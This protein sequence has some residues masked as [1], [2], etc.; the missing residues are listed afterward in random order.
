MDPRQRP[1]AYQ[2]LLDGLKAAAEDTRLRLLA[3]LGEAELTVS[4]L[5][6][7]LGQSQPRISRHLKLLV[8]AGLIERFR[9]ASWTFHRRAAEGPGAALAKALAA[10]IDARDPVLGRD[11]ERL[12]QVRAARAAAAQAYFRK[13]ARQWDEIRGLHVAEGAVEAAVREALGGLRIDTLL[14]LGTGTGRMLELFGPE[15][16]RGVGID[17]NPEMLAMARANLE[18]AGLKHCTVRQGDIY[19]L[20]LGRETFDVVILHQVLHFLDDG[21][22]AIQEAARM[23][24]PGGRLLVVDFAPHALEFLRDLHAHRRLGFAEDS[25]AQWMHAAGLEVMLHRALAP[26][27]GGARA[28]TV[29]LWLGRDPRI[30]LAQPAREV[31]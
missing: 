9:E 14:D 29:S 24:R 13:H 2:P 6:E 1:L 30:V 12:G 7:I 8:E 10:L 15:V 17:L 19:N 22:R 23:L 4:D 5:T 25:V 3:L 21:G 11:R 31:A 18:R 26:D 27:K 20:G 28:L 16:E